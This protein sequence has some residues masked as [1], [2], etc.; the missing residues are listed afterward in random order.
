MVRLL[1]GEEDA[2]ALFQAVLGLGGPRHIAVPYEDPEQIP[3]RTSWW[4]AEPVPL[5]RTLVRNGRAPALSGP[6]RIERNEEQ[7]QRLRAE[8]LKATA[9]RRAAASQLATD[10][11]Y[12][13]RLD[14][15]ETRAL[16]GLLDLALAARVPVSRKVA[17]GT[18]GTGGAA[19]APSGSAHGV[20]LTLRPAPG[21][22]SVD[23]VR[24]RL[25]LDGL[26]LELEAVR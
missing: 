20:R 16:L 18:G 10:G 24:G 15:P 22:T 6:G 23:T 11:V 25:L 12:G 9:E 7:R 2:H 19:D 17:G 4:E 13:R 14:E 3:G 21:S 8:Q 1:P 26:A 5:A